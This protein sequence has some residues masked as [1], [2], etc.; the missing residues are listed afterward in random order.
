MIIN[1]LEWVERKAVISEVEA[2]RS[3][4]M[5]EMTEISVWSL[6]RGSEQS[7]PYNRP[8]NPRGRE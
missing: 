2:V 4:C 8:G 6:G 5:G 3:V 7:S 1:E